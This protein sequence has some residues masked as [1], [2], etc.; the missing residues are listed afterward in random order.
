MS[1]IEQKLLD[2]ELLFKRL[3]SGE[4]TEVCFGKQSKPQL[5]L[6][7]IRALPCEGKQQF[8]ITTIENGRDGS[9]RFFNKGFDEVRNAL[10]KVLA[11]YYVDVG[12]SHPLILKMYS[13]YKDCVFYVDQPI[14]TQS[15]SS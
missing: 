6:L 12:S 2:A 11:K 5:C 4:I 14:A 8:S 3:Q 10:I 9:T 1:T 13:V 7:M 15:T